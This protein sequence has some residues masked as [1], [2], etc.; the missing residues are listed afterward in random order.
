MLSF[1]LLRT[2]LCALVIS[3]F[4][5]GC[6]QGDARLDEKA[7]IEGH[8]SGEAN[9]E[10]QNQNLAAKATAMEADLVIRRKFIESVTGTYE[11]FLIDSLGRSNSIRLTVK[12]SFPR[13]PAGDR[14]RTAEELTYELSNLHLNIQ[15]VEWFSAGGGSNDLE[16][17]NGCVFENVRPDMTEG[18]IAMISEGCKGSYSLS[19]ILSGTSEDEIRSSAGRTETSR[20]V[21]AEVLFGQR[22]VID[23]FVGFKQ[24]I[25]SSRQFPVRLSKVEN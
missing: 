25:L 4:T 5:M 11:G 14:A 24:S 6:N 21:A 8:A 10:V 7:R 13:Y 22:T 3:M 2:S 16:M 1:S 23:G 15:I 9:V 12:S 19:A 20:R 18:T 17:A